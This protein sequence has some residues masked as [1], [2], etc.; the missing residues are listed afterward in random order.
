MKKCFALLLL[1]PLVLMPVLFSGCGPGAE[2][3]LKESMRASKEINTLHFKVES[4]I[5]LP[6]APIEE[7]KV[8]KQNYVQKSEGDIDYRTGDMRIETEL[9][10]GVPVTMLQVGEKQ[11]WEIAG[12]WYE[13]PQSVQLPP[14]VTQALSTS[15]YLQY[16]KELEKLSDTK[17]DGEDCYHVRGIPDMKALVKLPGVTDLLKDPEGNQ[18][19]TVDELE[20]LKAEFNFY[21][22]K[23]NDYFKSSM[24][25]VEYRATDDLIKLGY[26]K[27]GDMVTGEA[28][29]VLSDYNKK[30]TIKAP[31]NVSPLPLP[32]Q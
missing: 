24:E 15:Q 8:A 7:G 21:V 23:K 28:T 12:N 9:A 16:F 17:I 20:E 19:R 18:V 25:V 6:A 13:A 1:V 32:A 31:E 29:V 22:Q 10:P 5:K 11:Y 30:L 4:T 3:I 14:P 2:E 26:A 27:P